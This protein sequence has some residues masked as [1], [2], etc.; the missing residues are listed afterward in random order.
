[1]SLLTMC[2]LERKP[3]VFLIPLLVSEAKLA[4][5]VFTI[6]NAKISIHILVASVVAKANI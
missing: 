5:T 6:P 3:T 4:V 1:M 2:H